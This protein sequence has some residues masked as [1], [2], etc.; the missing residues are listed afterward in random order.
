MA[1]LCPCVETNPE[2]RCA[3][4]G[5]QNDAA[6]QAGVLPGAGDFRMRRRKSVADQVPVSC[7]GGGIQ[8]SAN[9]GQPYRRVP[10]N[11]AL[12]FLSRYSPLRALATVFLTRSELPTSAGI[13]TVH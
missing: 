10:E 11:H 1:V 2:M 4:H 8:Q 7:Q 6:A 3:W 5:C 12:L 13:C 9:S